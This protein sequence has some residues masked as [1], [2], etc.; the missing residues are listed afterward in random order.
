[1]I[2]IS[3]IGLVSVADDVDAQMRLRQLM[4]EKLQTSQKLLE[5]IAKGDLKQIGQQADRLSDSGI[6][7]SESSKP[8]LERIGP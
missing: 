1:M 8:S 5:A 6:S 2:A 7:F 4:I 3:A